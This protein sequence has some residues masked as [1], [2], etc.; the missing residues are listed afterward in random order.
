MLQAGPM[1]PYGAVVAAALLLGA[2]SARADPTPGELAAARE[3][4]ARAEKD[5]DAG[6]WAEALD[7]VRRA[8]SV[9]MTAGLRFHIALCEEKLGQLVAALADYTAAEEAYALAAESAPEG[10]D[11]AW[12]KFQQANA[13]L[14]MNE[15]AEGIGLLD[16]VAASDAPFAEDARLKAEYAR[17]ELRLRSRGPAPSSTQ[18]G[19]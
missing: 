18:M 15:F 2:L 8:S 9:K 12:A 19:G 11:A 14:N 7:K 4:F 10:K 17:L 6:R 1:R 3:L 13:R 5:E 16:E